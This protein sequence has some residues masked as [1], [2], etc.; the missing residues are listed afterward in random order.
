MFPNC[1]GLK[2]QVF[3][4]TPDPTFLYLTPGHGEALAQLMDAVQGHKR[5]VVLAGDLK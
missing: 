5:F 1:C 4:P 2:E 3:D